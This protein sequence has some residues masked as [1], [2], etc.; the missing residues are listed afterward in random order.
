MRG[1]R[2]ALLICLALLAL[3]GAARADDSP[4]P[5]VREPRA[6]AVFE[7]HDAEQVY[8]AKSLRA[9]RI[10]G[11]NRGEQVDSWVDWQMGQRYTFEPWAVDGDQWR[12][13]WSLTPGQR[14]AKWWVGYCI[15]NCEHYVCDN[16]VGECEEIQAELAADFD[17]AL[18]KVTERE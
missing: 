4:M 13:D 15:I 1:L 10:L 14:F 7:P 2:G 8:V 6:P 12:A 11:W 16:R 17:A 18:A 5:I 9:M 3:A